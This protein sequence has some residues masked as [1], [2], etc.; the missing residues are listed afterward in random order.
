MLREANRNHKHEFYLTQIKQMESDIFFN[1]I[2]NSFYIR[3]FAVKNRATPQRRKVF[4]LFQSATS[5]LKE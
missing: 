2:K 4:H 3:S 1:L 5:V